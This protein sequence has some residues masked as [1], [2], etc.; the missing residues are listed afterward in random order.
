MKKQRKSAKPKDR[1]SRQNNT[2]QQ[3]S[4]GRRNFLRLGRNIGIGAV[5]LGG[6]GY[7]FAQNFVSMRHEHDLTRVA[8]GRPTVVQI[9]DPQCSLCR[10]LQADTRKALDMFED[11]ELDYVVANIRTAKGKTFQNRYGVPHVTL[12]LFDGK[13]ELQE[14]LQGQRGAYELRNHFQ[15]LLDG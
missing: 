15:A 7:V 13:G 10:S 14:V 9:H 6:T 1:K 11:G 2:Q 5:L 3:V 12:L 4:A 8:N